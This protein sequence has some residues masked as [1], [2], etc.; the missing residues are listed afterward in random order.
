MMAWPHLLHGCDASGG[1]SPGMNVFASQPGQ[2]T[3]FNGRSLMLIETNLSRP[4]N[5]TSGEKFDKPPETAILS[6]N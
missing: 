1:K 2:V 6:S 5:S 4:S 3:I